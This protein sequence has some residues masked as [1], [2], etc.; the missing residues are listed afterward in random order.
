MPKP[1]PPAAFT[2]PLMRLG[3]T[4]SFHFVPLPADVGQTFREAKVRRVLVTLNGQVFRRGLQSDGEGGAF[5]LFGLPILRSLRVKEGD[6]IRVVI[7][8]DPD[9]DHIELGDELTAVLDQDEEAAARFYGF[10][11]GRQRSYAYYVTSAKRVETRLKRA[12]ELAHKL[13]THTLYDDLEGRK[14]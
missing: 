10:T 11:P 1:P 5:I 4:M 13:R 12:M 9:P 8:A 6:E 14:G 2:A 7:A 3:G